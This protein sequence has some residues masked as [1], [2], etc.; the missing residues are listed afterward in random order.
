T[1]DSVSGPISHTKVTS[2]LLGGAMSAHNKMMLPSFGEKTLD[3]M[4]DFKLND[5]TMFA[6][7]KSMVEM[8]KAEISVSTAINGAFANGVAKLGT[9]LASLGDKIDNLG[10]ILSNTFFG[11]PTAYHGPTSGT[12]HVTST[13]VH[14]RKKGE[15]PISV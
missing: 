12:G 8:S 7:N 6:L 5:E 15:A 2:S 9:G 13:G 4:G 3:T 10:T 1:G 11:T 14:M